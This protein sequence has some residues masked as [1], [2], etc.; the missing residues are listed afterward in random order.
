MSRFDRLVLSAGRRIGLNHADAADAAQLTWLRLLEHAHQIRE[1]ECLPAWLAA[2]ARRE[3]LRIATD[4]KRFVLRADPT[5]ENGVDRRGAVDDVYPADG[6]YGPELEE[7]LGR[8]PA[9]YQDLL[10]LLMSDECPAYTEVAVQ[11]HIP[12]GSIG[13]MRMRALAML[14]RTPEFAGAM[15]SRRAA[16]ERRAA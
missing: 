11:L 1:P 2:T 9:G 3:A 13:P 5:I 16:L 8:L 6:H 7:A 4:A 12:I 10:R 15:V 14:R